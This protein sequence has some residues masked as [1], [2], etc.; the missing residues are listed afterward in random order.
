MRGAGL[1][2]RFRADANLKPGIGGG[3]GRREPAID[4]RG[5]TGVI[6]EGTPDPEVLQIAAAA[7]RVMVSR[8]VTTMPDH[9]ERFVTEHEPPGV[10]LIP[11]QRSIGD[12]RTVDRLADLGAVM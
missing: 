7:G 10:S 6:P 4:F 12:R 3:V 2:F 5:A 9:F 1:C 8:D 11:S